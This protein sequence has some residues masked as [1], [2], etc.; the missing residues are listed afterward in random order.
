MTLLPNL[1]LYLLFYF[2]DEKIVRIRLE[3]SDSPQMWPMRKF[4]KLKVKNINIS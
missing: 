4:D 3:Q 1:K 2:E